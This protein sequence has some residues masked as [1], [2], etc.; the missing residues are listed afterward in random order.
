LGMILDLV[1][2][3][4]ERSRLSALFVN[5]AHLEG[6]NALEMLDGLCKSKEKEALRKFKYLSRELDREEYDSPRYREIQEEIKELCIKKS[7]LQ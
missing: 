5:D 6:I 7:Q 1:E 4:E 2:A 3:P